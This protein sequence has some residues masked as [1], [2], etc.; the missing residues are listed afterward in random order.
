M[1]DFKNKILLVTGA[2]SGIA[3]ATAEYFHAC[4]AHVMLGDINEAAAAAVA[5][6]LDPSG[7]S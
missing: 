6:A 5:Q 4:G 7:L 1:F 2:G 3:R